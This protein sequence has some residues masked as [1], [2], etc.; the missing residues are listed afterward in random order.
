MFM[1][2]RA[3]ERPFVFYAHRPGTQNAE[4]RIE[5]TFACAAASE[6][7]ARCAIS[8]GGRVSQFF[9]LHSDFCIP[10]RAR[11]LRHERMRV[12]SR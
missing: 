7:E 1:G 2:E 8:R 4:L 11:R 5:N 6:R 3:R 9:I 10:A 12:T